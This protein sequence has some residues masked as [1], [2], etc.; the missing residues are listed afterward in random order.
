VTEQVGLP[1][2]PAIGATALRDGTFDGQTVFV[3]GGGT[4]LG[5]AIAAEFARLG[6]S[7]VIASRKEEHL[8]AARAAIAGLGV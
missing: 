6:A 8:D 4:G 1:R 7:L 2:P 3:T 5:K